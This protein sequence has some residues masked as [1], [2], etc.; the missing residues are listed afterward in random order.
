M[1]TITKFIKCVLLLNIYSAHYVLTMI[2]LHILFYVL[3]L[4]CLNI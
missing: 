2:I 3:D 1:K 4:Y